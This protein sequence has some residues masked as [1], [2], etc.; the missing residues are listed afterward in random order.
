MSYTLYKCFVCKGI[1][2]TLYGSSPP[3][4]CLPGR[5]SAPGPARPRGKLEGTPGLAS[6]R[7]LLGK[8]QPG[9]CVRKSLRSSRAQ[10]AQ[11]T[12]AELQVALV[13]SAARAPPSASRS[14]P[15]LAALSAFRLAASARRFA[16]NPGTCIIRGLTPGNGLSVQQQG[17][18]LS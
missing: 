10:R 15:E 4:S 11:A 6:T 16:C 12:I 13:T 3:S 7:R 17:T 5:R 1:Y 9:T 14:C 18:V 2:Y 8:G